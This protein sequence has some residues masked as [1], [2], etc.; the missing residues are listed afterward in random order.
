MRRLTTVLVALLLFMGSLSGNQMT[1][2]AEETEKEETGS[3]YELC[4]SA[5]SW[6]EFKALFENY[7]SKPGDSNGR[8]IK[9][10]SE[11]LEALSTFFSIGMC[12]LDEEAEEFGE[13]IKYVVSLYNQKDLL[14][15][16]VTIKDYTGPYSEIL[17]QADKVKLT[18]LGNVVVCADI[19]YYENI[20]AYQEQKKA[21][22]YDKQIL[23]Y[24]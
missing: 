13:A 11:N 14:K 2:R 8:V 7:K 4:Y 10:V 20:N 17:I 23:C 21:Y 9:K 24:T 5:K 1:V 22:Y 15:F 12:V 3:A 18:H 6:E 19:P 16:S